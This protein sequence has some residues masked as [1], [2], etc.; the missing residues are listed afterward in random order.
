MRKYTAEYARN[1]WFLGHCLKN[2]LSNM[3]LNDFYEV[4]NNNSRY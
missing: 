4:S 1:Q 2:L 3:E